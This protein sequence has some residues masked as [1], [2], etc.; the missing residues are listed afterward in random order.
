M[1]LSHRH[2]NVD[3]CLHTWSMKGL[4]VNVL[5]FAGH[6][7]SVTAAELGEHGGRAAID[8]MQM[9]EPFFVGPGAAI[10]S[11][12][13]DG[14]SGHRRAGGASKQ[15]HSV[16]CSRCCWR[17]AW[18]ARHGQSTAALVIMEHRIQAGCCSQDSR[19]KAGP[20]GLC[21]GDR[22]S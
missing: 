20:P 1:L 14:Y 11:A 15:H 21:D 13:C 12:W 22:V 3:R 8:S 5:G 2:G 19:E 16:G 9:R 18:F 17:P 6:V 4:V 10:A 7:L